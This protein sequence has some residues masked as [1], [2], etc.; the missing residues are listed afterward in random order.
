MGKSNA[1]QW[2]DADQAIWYTL[3]I[4]SAVAGGRAAACAPVLTS[5]PPTLAA[6]E[7]VVANG[8]FGR[9]AFY[10]AGDGSYSHSTTVA[11]G[12]APFVVGMLAVSAI[13]NAAR[14]SAAAAAANP[15]WRPL[16]SGM[17]FV[18]TAG[19]YLQTG[20]G[21]YPWGWWAITS[22]EMVGRGQVMVQGQSA[23]GQGVAWIINSPWSELLFTLWALARHRSHPQ[24][25]NGGWIP[26]GWI[27]HA[28]A[29]G[30]WPERQVTELV[31]SLPRQ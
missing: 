19:F 23:D 12:G 31:A 10:A 30:R 5:F 6:G 3:D 24:L 27:D 22:A 26:P 20:Q 9:L 4:V 7:R 8:G 1:P 2:T 18:S 11:V 29:H 28:Q 16:D 21:L 17:V 13:G 14:R 25:L 15:A